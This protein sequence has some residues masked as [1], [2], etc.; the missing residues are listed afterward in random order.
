MEIENP[1]VPLTYDKLFKSLWL[2]GSKETRNYFNR[3]ISNIVNFDISNFILIPNELP[4]KRKDSKGNI[5]DILL[6]SP[7]KKIKINIE[8]NTKYN[9]GLSNRNESYL[10]KIAGEYYAKD[11]KTSYIDKIK[12]IQVNLNNFYS[13]DRKEIGTSIYT[14]KD[15]DNNLDLNSIKIINIYIPILSNLCYNQDM[16]KQ[17][18]YVMFDATSFKEMAIYAKGNK[19]RESVMKDMEKIVNQYK[20]MQREYEEEKYLKDVLE[21]DLKEAKED[22][23]KEG[24]ITG[25]QAGIKE[26]RQEERANLLKLINSGMSNEELSKRLSMPIL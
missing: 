19:E 4:I 5:V 7:D 16:E 3:L 23:I 9:K 14:L 17:L 24:I 6:E 12:V 1:F 15:K 13:K 18:D 20:A 21:A 25:R 8:L 22:G 2:I 10:Y 11:N 26:G